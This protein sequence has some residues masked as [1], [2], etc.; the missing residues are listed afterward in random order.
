M[1][2]LRWF[3]VVKQTTHPVVRLPNELGLLMK[4]FLVNTKPPPKITFNFRTNHTFE[5]ILYA[6]SKHR[7]RSWT[8]SGNFT[9]KSPKIELLRGMKT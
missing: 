9:I 6:Q 2:V 5:L 8:F 7:A 1:T 4:L 3:S